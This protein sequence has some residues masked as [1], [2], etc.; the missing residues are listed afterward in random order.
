MDRVTNHQSKRAM[1]EKTKNKLTY[2]VCFHSNLKKYGWDWQGPRICWLEYSW[3]PVDC[4]SLDPC[5]CPYT[6]LDVRPA[7]AIHAQF[8]KS[9]TDEV[10]LLCRKSLVWSG[11]VVPSTITICLRS[12]DLKLFLGSPI[13]SCPACRAYHDTNG[14]LPHTSVSWHARLRIG[15]LILLL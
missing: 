7:S 1:A 5:M 11:L 2:C 12:W 8:G 14:G 10:S 15:V 13:L 3:I 9:R 6:M 4:K